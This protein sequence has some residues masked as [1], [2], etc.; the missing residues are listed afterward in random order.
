MK[1]K[2]TG[3]IY[4]KEAVLG[5]RNFKEKLSIIYQKI[6]TITHLTIAY[7]YNQ[8]ISFRST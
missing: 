1:E 5:F 8:D 7:G 2:N 6:Q 4:L 3:R